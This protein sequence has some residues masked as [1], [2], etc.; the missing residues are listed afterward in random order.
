VKSTG[1][2]TTAKA[3]AKKATTRRSTAKKA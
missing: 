3:P 1:R 2:K